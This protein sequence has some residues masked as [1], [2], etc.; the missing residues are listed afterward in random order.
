MKNNTQRY[1]LIIMLVHLL[2]PLWADLDEVARK[3]SKL[4]FQSEHWIEGYNRAVSGEWIH[5]N[6]VRGDVNRALLTRTTTGDKTIIWETAPVPPGQEEETVTFLWMAGM[7][8]NRGP[9]EFTLNINDVPRFIFSNG[10]GADWS[11]AGIS[12]GTLSFATI[13]HDQH[14]DGFGYMWMAVPRDWCEAGKSLEIKVVGSARNSTAWYMTFEAPDALA[15]LQNE[16]EYEGWI[17]LVPWDQGGLVSIDIE[18]SPNWSERVLFLKT[19]GRVLASCTLVTQDGRASGSSPLN[20]PSSGIDMPL[21][22]FL[23]DRFIGTL[24][25]LFDAFSETQL[26]NESVVLLEAGNDREEEKWAIRI[27][28]FYRPNLIGK[29][30]AVSR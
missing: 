17:T 2:L 12:G 7:D 24:P 4:A 18:A 29:L 21:Q 30:Q 1:I 26:H 3:K 27:S 15:F 19:T 10:P 23:D 25:R 20:I 22:L 13:K 14:G 28:L 9:Y 11:V 6:S 5:Y 16:A 8:M